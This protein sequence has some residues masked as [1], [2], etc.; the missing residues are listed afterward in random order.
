MANSLLWSPKNHTT[1]IERFSKKVG[2]FLT[3]LDYNTLHSWSIKKKYEFWSEF[4]DFSEIIG[5]KK[6]P[7]IENEKNFIESIFFKNCKLNFR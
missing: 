1:S 4:W 7:V 2:N 6:G 5:E 3:N